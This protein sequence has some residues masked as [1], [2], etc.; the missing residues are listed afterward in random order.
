[1]LPHSAGVKMLPSHFLI[2]T[3]N[4]LLRYTVKLNVV[5]LAMQSLESMNKRCRTMSGGI[6]RNERSS[7]RI[8][9]N[10]HSIKFATVHYIYILI[11]NIKLFE[12]S[13][14]RINHLFADSLDV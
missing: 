3:V 12:M 8:S 2:L 9:R 14:E 6:I 5:K 1:M 11:F 4:G 13:T 10:W 7:V